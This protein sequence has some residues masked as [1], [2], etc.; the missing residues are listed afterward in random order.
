MQKRC[1]LIVHFLRP[2]V[3]VFAALLTERNASIICAMPAPGESRAGF[4]R[5]LM[6]GRGTEEDFRSLFEQYHHAVSAFFFRKGFSQEDGRDLT[7]EVFV[8]VHQSIRNLRSEAAFVSW[9]FSIANHVALRYWER[10]RARPKL[11][12]VPVAA[13]AE[14]PGS[15]GMDLIPSLG[16]DPER[17][18]LDVE[19]THIV[20]KALEAL[21][22]RV[23]DCL[24]ARL[25]EGLGNKEISERL[26]ISESTVA[27]HVHRGIESLKSY[28][29]QYL[30]R[31][32]FA[33]D[34]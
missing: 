11:Q 6:E 19:K 12:P 9:L 28:L 20:H 31:L 29:Q 3:E 5:P 8:A 21:P 33:G 27:V 2:G 1:G 25:L 7:Q 34:F 24:R 22:A 14:T 18:A 15:D 17:Q 4:V 16:P 23:R 32:P 30:G 10:E 13:D 26:G